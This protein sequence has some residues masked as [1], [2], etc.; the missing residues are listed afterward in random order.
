MARPIDIR[1]NRAT[2]EILAVD[3]ERRGDAAVLQLCGELD[4]SSVALLR[5]AVD[6]VGAP[7]T[8]ALD[9]RGLSFIDSSGLHF[10]VELHERA[11]REAFELC[12]MAP[13]EPADRPIR[14]CGLDRHLPFVSELPADGL[15]A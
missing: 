6:E 2:R 11:A 13:R 5:A 4:L 7:S 15:A 9:L 12:L 8:L 10:L 14:L 1:R 3:L